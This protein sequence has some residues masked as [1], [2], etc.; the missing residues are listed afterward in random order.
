MKLTF[1][2]L[3]EKTTAPQ[4]A[5]IFLGYLVIPYGILAFLLTEHG[6]QFASKIFETLCK[7]HGENP[8]TITVYY[9]RF[10]GLAEWYNI[11]IVVRLHHYVP[12]HPRNCDSFV[13]HLPY[14]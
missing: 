1:T 14:V 3:S 12:E 13:Q 2:I 5:S 10:N 4:A 7:F 11:T 9:V 8:L 6:P